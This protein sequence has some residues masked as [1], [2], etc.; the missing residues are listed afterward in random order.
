MGHDPE[1]FR[2]KLDEMRRTG[3]VPG[4][5]RRPTHGYIPIR[6]EDTGREIGTYRVRDDRHPEGAGQD[7]RVTPETIHVKRKIGAP[8]ASE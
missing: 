7:A 3:S 8:H 1:A 2:A 6:S 5:N 4:L